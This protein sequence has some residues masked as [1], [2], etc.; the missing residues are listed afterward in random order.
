MRAEA[1]ASGR[2][3]SARRRSRKS[4]LL[5]GAL[6]GSPL[7]EGRACHVFPRRCASH[8]DRLASPLAGTAALR[9]CPHT[10]WARWLRGDARGVCPPPRPPALR[11][12]G[13]VVSRGLALHFGGSFSCTTRC[14]ELGGSSPEG[15]GHF[16]VVVVVV[17]NPRPPEECP[18]QVVV[19]RSFWIQAPYSVFVAVTLEE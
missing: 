8:A 9:R 4:R 7:P 1:A 14:E 15:A 16:L 11:Q 13:C 3:S 17:P 18:V 10:R 6:G 2:S 19:G 5:A 12:R